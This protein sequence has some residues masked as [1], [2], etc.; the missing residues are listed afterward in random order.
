MLYVDPHALLALQRIALLPQLQVLVRLGER[1]G[2]TSTR[3]RAYHIDSCDQRPT[4][5]ALVNGGVTRVDGAST[6]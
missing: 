3:D 4:D 1:A 2:E 6:A 5:N